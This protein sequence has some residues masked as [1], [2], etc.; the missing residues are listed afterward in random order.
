MILAQNIS[1]RAM[2]VRLQRNVLCVGAEEPCPTP[3]LLAGTLAWS[4]LPNPTSGNYVA[5]H[6]CR[7]GGKLECVA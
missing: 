3:M 1:D 4:Y 5:C 7:Y 2:L 6:A